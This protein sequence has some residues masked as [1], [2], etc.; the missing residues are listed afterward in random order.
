MFIPT[1]INTTLGT[2]I[3]RFVVFFGL[4]VTWYAPFFGGYLVRQCL[5][6]FLQPLQA[7]FSQVKFLILQAEVQSMIFLEDGLIAVFVPIFYVFSPI[8]KFFPVPQ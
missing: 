2:N 5:T 8:G 3:F 7:R 1:I 6:Y 4:F